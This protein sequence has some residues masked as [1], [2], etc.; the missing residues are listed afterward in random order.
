[1]T[2]WRCGWTIAPA[3]VIGACNTILSHATSNV[4]SISQKAAIGALTGPQEGVTQMLDEYRKR[5]DAMHSWLTAHPSIRC[6]KPKGAFYLFP[7][8]SD[9]L[10]PGGISTSGQLAEQLLEKAHVAL[11]PGEAFDAP[12]Y[13]RI[14]YATSMDTLRDAAT[15]ILEFADALAPGSKPA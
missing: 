2:G 14:S 5:R 3:Q 4:A 7:D 8:F 1:M 10:S 9:L 15:R 11:T 6:V 12:G 13:A